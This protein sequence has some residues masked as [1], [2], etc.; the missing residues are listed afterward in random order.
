MNAIRRF[1]TLAFCLGLMLCAGCSKPVDYLSPERLDKGL[2]V[3]LD[4]V[5]G[6]NWGPRWL[7]SGLDEGGVPGAIYIFSWG[8]GPAGMFVADLWDHEGNMKRAA[9]MVNLVRNYRKFYPGR[10]VNLVGHS[11]G[12]GMVVFALEQMP[13]GFQV[14]NAFLLAPALSPDYNLAAALRHVRQ[15]CY[16]TH[17]PGDVPLMGLGTSVFTTMDGKHT[18]GAGLIGFKVPQG[19]S[20][21]DRA[22]YVKIRQAAWGGEFLKKGHLGGHMGWSTSSFAREFLAPIMLTGQSHEAFQPIVPAETRNDE[23]QATQADGDEKKG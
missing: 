9:E 3:S 7:R 20:D 11:G 8:H 23:P 12:G 6:Y 15:R 5:G 13:E 1:L 17:S 2:V 10:P 16:V 18:V 4:G 14:D 21:E 19:L 22:Q